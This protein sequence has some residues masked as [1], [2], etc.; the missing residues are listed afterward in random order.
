MIL[1]EQLIQSYASK[2]RPV[3]L[4]YLGLN[5][6]IAAAR[7]TCEYFS[8]HDITAR[9]QPVKFVVEDKA[10]NLAFCSGLSDE[11]RATAKQSTKLSE[12]WNGHLIVIADN[13]Y[14]LDPS[15]DQALAALGL[16]P[17]I[18]MLC[19]EN[20]A[21]GVRM[22]ELLDITLVMRMDDGAELSVRYI[23]LDDDSY[24]ETE[25]W[26][27]DGLPYLVSEIALRI[28]A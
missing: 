26:N 23:P 25:A 7:V 14:I 28:A 13:R 3:M 24:L 20:N 15:F 4:E 2:A 11:E 22:D 9:V 27:D 12:G 16:K 19:V 5:S 10:R 17:E 8:R 18:G 6:C 21:A 1:T